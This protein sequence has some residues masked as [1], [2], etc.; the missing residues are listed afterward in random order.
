MPEEIETQPKEEQ[1][2]SDGDRKH[3][4]GVL[5]FISD[6][7]GGGARRFLLAGILGIFVFA[8]ALYSAYKLG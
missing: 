1:I 5:S 4:R 6:H 8:G 2:T 7:L 3:L